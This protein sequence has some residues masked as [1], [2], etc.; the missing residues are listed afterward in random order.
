[1]SY[2]AKLQAGYTN[3]ILL[4]KWDLV[5]ERELDIVLDHVY[6]LNEDT[7]KLKYTSNL[8]LN[9]L[10]G[11]DTTLFNEPAP[12]P[13]NMQNHMENEVDIL[14][15]TKTCSGSWSSSDVLA[16]FETFD[17]QHVYRIKG[18]LPLLHDNEVRMMIV[19]YAFKSTQLT[20]MRHPETLEQFQGTLQL[21][22][23]GRELRLLTDA[24]VKFFGLNPDAHLK[25]HEAHHH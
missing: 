5:T 6:L 4:N 7:P 14:T 21:T 22:I 18:W 9:F 13:F 15:I 19:N 8:S 24:F 1:T 20:P 3:V 16:F 25:L 2:T 10:F 17:K 11:L 12:I 23:M